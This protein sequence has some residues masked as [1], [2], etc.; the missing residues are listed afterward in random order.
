MIDPGK[1]GPKLLRRDQTKGP[2][3]RTQVMGPEEAIKA[4]GSVE[5]AFARSQTPTATH[6]HEENT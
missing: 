5:F 2:P 6:E 4:L 1:H 3:P